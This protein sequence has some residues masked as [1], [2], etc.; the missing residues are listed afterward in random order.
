MVSEHKSD[1]KF[2]SPRKINPTETWRPV[3]KISKKTKIIMIYSKLLFVE[4]D[5]YIDKVLY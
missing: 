4:K 2:P 5:L 1:P 3:F